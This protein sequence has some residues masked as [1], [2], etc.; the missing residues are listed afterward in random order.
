M[1]IIF[2]EVYCTV[3]STCQHPCFKDK[4][5]YLY[6]GKYT[7]QYVHVNTLVDEFLHLYRQSEAFKIEHSQFAENP[8]V[9][10]ESDS[11]QNCTQF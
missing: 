7:V 9:S 3:Y 1:L 5:C 8:V 2:R 11:V 4:K 10:A 6:L